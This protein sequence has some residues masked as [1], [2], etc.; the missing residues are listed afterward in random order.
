MHLHTHSHS[1]LQIYVFSIS[2]SLLQSLSHPYPLIP[3]PSVSYNHGRKTEKRQSMVEENSLSEQCIDIM[4]RRMFVKEG[5]HDKEVLLNHTT[6]ISEL[7]PWKENG[8]ETVHGGRGQSQWAVHRHDEE[9]SV[10]EGGE[11]DKE[12]L[13]DRTTII[14]DR[15]HL[16]QTIL[17]KKLTS[18]IPTTQY[19]AT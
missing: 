11:H 6:T 10:R 17:D 18:W 2:Q 12:I 5:E 9:E 16:R 1:N 3:P 19:F 4:K 15:G 14:S 13:L 8:K 7:Q